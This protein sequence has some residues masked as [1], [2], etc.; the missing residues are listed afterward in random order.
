MPKK[1]E[2]KKEE[3]SVYASP[4]WKLKREG[5][6]LK[7]IS[8]SGFYPHKKDGLVKIKVTVEEE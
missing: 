5:T 1:T 6:E 8:P 3:I 7:I 2:V 4:S